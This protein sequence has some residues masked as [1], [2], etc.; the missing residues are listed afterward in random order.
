MYLYLRF[1]FLRFIY[2]WWMYLWCKY[3][4]K[5]GK[6]DIYDKYTNI[7]NIWYIINIYEY[8]RTSLPALLAHPTVSIH[9]KSGFQKISQF[10]INIF[11]FSFETQTCHLAVFIKYPNSNQ[12]FPLTLRHV[13]VEPLGRLE[14]WW[15]WMLRRWLFMHY[16]LSNSTCK[17][18]L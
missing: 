12:N 16:F 11:N 15:I 9:I 2:P 18:N 4:P 5:L 3:W 7:H 10:E 6:W 17:V 8:L 13:K 14:I 1:N